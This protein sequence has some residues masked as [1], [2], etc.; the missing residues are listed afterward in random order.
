MPRNHE[1]YLVEHIAS[2][3]GG[4]WE[5]HEAVKNTANWL[6]YRG[7]SM[8]FVHQ[9][10]SLVRHLELSFNHSVW[11]NM[12]NA[13]KRGWH[14]STRWPA[15]CLLSVRLEYIWQKWCN[16]VG[17]NRIPVK[18]QSIPRAHIGMHVDRISCT[19]TLGLGDHDRCPQSSWYCCNDIMIN[20][21]AYHSFLQLPKHVRLGVPMSW[22]WF[23]C[24]FH[25]TSSYH[26]TSCNELIAPS[27]GG[28]AMLWCA[29]ENKSNRVQGELER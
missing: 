17:Y 25:H 27:A 2:K 13:A 29:Y 7:P 8:S 24:S 5:C 26:S 4:I 10:S 1:A 22:D 3:N 23:R 28:S 11:I 20:P 12:M 15:A 14:S 18:L 6:E 21:Q 9:A 19:A 16:K